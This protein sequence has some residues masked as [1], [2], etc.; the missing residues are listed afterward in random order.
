MSLPTYPS[1]VDELLGLFK[2]HWDAETPALNGGSP[3]H[4][5]WPGVD[6]GSPPPPDKPYARVR[7][8]HT[9]SQQ[10]TFGPV[11]SRR[12]NRPGFV[13][14]QVF[15]PLTRGFGLTFA[16]NLAIIARDAYEG[17]GTAS[18]IWFR[19]STVQDI[20]EDGTWHQMNVVVEFEYDEMK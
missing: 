18:G 13:T 1:A 16:E 5:E 11:G 20:G 6:S 4:V 14:V 2:A 12:F 3:V 7:V 17:R 9:S 15:A 19:R 10:L 8:R